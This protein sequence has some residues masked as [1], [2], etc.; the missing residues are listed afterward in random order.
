MIDKFK[1]EQKHLRDYINHTSV[2]PT[3][4]IKAIK[5][6]FPKVPESYLDYLGNI[7]FGS[8]KNSAMMIY[9]DL[10]D[11]SDLGIECTFNIPKHIK[12]FGDNF[13][14]D[15]VGF[16]FSRDCEI[17]EYL[18]ETEEIYW[19]GK[20]FKEYISEIIFL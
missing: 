12:F 15:F 3:A 11:L 8:I 2:V 13:S 18:H 6:K 9:D 20:K 17:V 14:G 7:G 19:T 5:I 16:D 10:M 1:I 4:K